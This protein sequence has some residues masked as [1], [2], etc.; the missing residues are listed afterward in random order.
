VRANKTQAIEG[1]TIT[2]V[3]S[4]EHATLE[5]RKWPYNESVYSGQQYGTSM[6]GS[7]AGHQ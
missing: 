7:L 1:K 2:S 4:Q 6:I 3:H 5:N